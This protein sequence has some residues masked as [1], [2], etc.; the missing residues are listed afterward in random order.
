M[1]RS[2]YVKRTIKLILFVAIFLI[3]TV[4][5]DS[6]F[7]PDEA[8]TEKML[9]DYSNKSDIDTVFV[10]SSVGGIYDADLFSS[11]TGT[12]AYNMCTPSQGLSGSIMNVEL[13]SS[14]HKLENVILFITYDTF[15]SDSYSGIDL[16]FERVVNSKSPFHVRFMNALKRNLAISFASDTVRTEKS[17]NIWIPWEN[18]TVHGIESVRNNLTK[19]VGRLLRG[20]RLGSGIAFDLNERVYET[21]PGDLGEEDIRELDADLA[22]L[23][24]LPIP[25]G[26]IDP[27]KIRQL[28]Q[29][30]TYCRNKGINFCVVLAPHRSDYYDRYGDFRDYSDI[31]DEYIGR[32]VS[33]RG[34]VY[35][36]TED[37]PER[38]RRFPDSC[39]YDW[40]H[41]ED[42]YSGPVTEYIAGVLLEDR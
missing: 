9:T 17:V 24:E 30:C 14:H 4:I 2:E 5:L 18:G 32:F 13:A 31:A 21:A 35:Y 27:A 28:A 39:C 20:E 16:V 29:L 42:E 15:N 1:Q 34:F 38:H 33:D 8:V 41:L 40:E 10:G 23:S 22:E 12:D 19:R 7:M 26:L 11:L 36:N 37:D 6:A 25:E 3:L